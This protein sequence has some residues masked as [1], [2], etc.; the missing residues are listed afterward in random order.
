[1]PLELVQNLVQHFDQTHL[2]RQAVNGTQSTGGHT[3]RSPRHFVLNVCSREHRP[4]LIR[5][6]PWKK[7][8]VDSALAILQFSAIFSFHSK[9]SFG[10]IVTLAGNTTYTYGEG[11]FRVFLQIHRACAGTS[12]LPVI[13][14]L[15]FGRLA[16][17]HKGFQYFLAQPFDVCS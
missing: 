6:L 1:M 12:N 5:P 10:C 17:V 16:A 15:P 14:L 4:G 3:A 11:A 9:C 2:P 13:T 7:A 8:A